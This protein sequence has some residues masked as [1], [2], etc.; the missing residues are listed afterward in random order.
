MSAN[1]TYYARIPKLM[2][3]WV[4]VN[5]LVGAD[6]WEKYPTASDV[7]HWTEYEDMLKKEDDK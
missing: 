4:E 5:A 6:V 7:L 1:T 2:W 3:E